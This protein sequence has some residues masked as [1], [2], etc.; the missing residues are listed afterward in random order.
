MIKKKINK[1]LSAFTL[2]IPVFNNEKNIYTT[3]IKLKKFVNKNINI[4]FVNDGST[5]KSLFLLKKLYFKFENKIKIIDLKKNYGQI[6]A[7]IIGLNYIKTKYSIILSCDLQDDLRT[8]NKMFFLSN[9]YDL[10]V[11]NRFVRQEGIID[12]FFSRL[13]WSL[14]RILINKKIP[15]TGYDFCCIN[16]QNIKKGINIQTPNL[17]VELYVISK[18]IFVLNG[19]RYERK[20]GISGWTIIKKIE[21][22][23]KSFL[24]YTKKNITKTNT[25]NYKTY[26]KKIYE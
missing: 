16:H 5:D 2:L 11:S 26:V 1:S 8:L 21:L 17:F 23:I 25:K 3:Y 15:K 10:I 18:K 6:K 14:M 7:L 13:Y 24:F 4:I 20:I 22:F 9:N 12:K 19:K